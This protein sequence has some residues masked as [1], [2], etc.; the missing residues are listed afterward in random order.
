MS[1]GRVVGYVGFTI[2]C[3]AVVLLII[4]ASG[5]LRIAWAIL[6]LAGLGL[7]MLGRKLDS[8]QRMRASRGKRE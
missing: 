1:P 8:D 2:A 4:G 7:F 3:V 6:A 5:S